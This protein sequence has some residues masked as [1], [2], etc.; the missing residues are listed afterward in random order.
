MVVAT[1]ADRRAPGWADRDDLVRI[2]HDPGLEEQLQPAAHRFAA[3]EHAGP[4]V[5]AR[6]AEAD[7]GRVERQ[8]G[9]DVTRTVPCHQEADDLRR[10][11][12]EQHPK[13]LRD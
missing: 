2:G 3:G 12:G 4:A 9:A 8:R 11:P 1:H 7:V 6:E 13:H 10:K 5:L